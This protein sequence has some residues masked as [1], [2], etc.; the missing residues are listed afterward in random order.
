MTA[1]AKELEKIRVFF[2]AIK[3]PGQR[4]A[5]AKRC[6]TTVGQ[7]ANVYRGQR[8]PS[9]SMSIAFDRETGGQVRMEKLRPDVDWK[10]LK[11]T[12]ATR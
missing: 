1:A 7:I 9:V 6:R 10:Y 2:L 5:F 8:R 3:D 11:E 12:L 4:K